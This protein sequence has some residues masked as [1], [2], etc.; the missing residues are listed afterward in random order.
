MD[1]VGSIVTLL[2]SLVIFLAVFIII[3]AFV[4]WYW[5][6]NEALHFFEW[7]KNLLETNRDQNREIIRLLK[8]SVG[9]IEIEHQE[10]TTEYK[11]TAAKVHHGPGICPHCGHENPPTRNSCLKCF[12]YFVE[13]KQPL[14]E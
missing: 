1:I 11:K 10:S 9:E 7:Q 13:A 4:L 14:T 2:I 3:R 8:K 6:V 12:R 5:R